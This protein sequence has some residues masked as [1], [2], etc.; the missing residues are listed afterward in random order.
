MI[1]IYTLHRIV[2]YLTSRFV[3]SKSSP[4]YRTDWCMEFRG[5]VV[6]SVMWLL[7]I[8]PWVDSWTLQKN[9]SK[10]FALSIFSFSHQNSSKLN[11][12]R[13][14]T[15]QSLSRN[16]ENDRE[17]SCK[18]AHNIFLIQTFFELNKFSFC[19]QFSNKS[20]NHL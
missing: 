6:R 20:R 10:F 4:L 8:W 2:K 19:S 18:C 14:S 5:C 1:A 7:T 16:A 3:F 9:Q 11:L 12:S 15:G 13:D 17:H